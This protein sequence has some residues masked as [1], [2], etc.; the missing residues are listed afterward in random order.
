MAG[1]PPA[2]GRARATMMHKAGWLPRES[3]ADYATMNELGI[4][5]V[6]GGDRF[7]VSLLARHGLDSWGKQQSFLERASCV[8]YRA[9]AKDPSLGCRD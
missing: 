4:V 3:Y 9:I 2:G 8:I 6:P 5:Q 1:H 7:A